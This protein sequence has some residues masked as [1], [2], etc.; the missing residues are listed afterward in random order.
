MT[1]WSPKTQESC[2]RQIVLSARATCRTAAEGLQ[3]H[4]TLGLYTL[5]ATQLTKLKHRRTSCCRRNEDTSRLF[6]MFLPY[7]RMLYSQHSLLENCNWRDCWLGQ[8]HLGTCPPVHWSPPEGTEHCLHLHFSPVR[9]NLNTSDFQNCKA[10]N[11]CCFKLLR[12]I[13]ATAGN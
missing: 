1:N 2:L 7:L 8:G 4:P 5:G 3:W 10:I 9:S 11:L 6:W 13:I 12:F